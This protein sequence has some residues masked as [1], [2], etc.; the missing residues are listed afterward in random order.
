[1]L[2]EEWK[3]KKHVLMLYTW[4]PANVH[5]WRAVRKIH[6]HKEVLEFKHSHSTTQN[7]NLMKY[8]KERSCSKNP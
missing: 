8:T 1:M 7:Q 6:D 4:T 3:E 5:D 2:E